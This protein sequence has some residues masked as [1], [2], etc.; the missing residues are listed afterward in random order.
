MD[1]NWTMS[2]PPWRRSGPIAAL[3]HVVGAPKAGLELSS[4]IFAFAGLGAVPHGM[5]ETRF[6]G[7][8]SPQPCA[9][10]VARLGHPPRRVERW[11]WAWSCPDHVE[12]LTGRLWTAAKLNR[13]RTCPAPVRI[14]G[15]TPLGPARKDQTPPRTRL[16]SNLVVVDPRFEVNKCV[17]RQAGGVATMPELC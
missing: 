11:W 6:G 7:E 2:P 13:R 15:D 8:D 4:K 9:I 14:Q 3:G 10:T 12:G 16:T 17:K 1:E 5:V